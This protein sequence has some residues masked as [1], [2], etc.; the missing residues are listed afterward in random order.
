LLITKNVPLL[1]SS[2]VLQQMAALYSIFHSGQNQIQCS[3]L[4][5]FCLTGQLGYLKAVVNLKTVK[6]CKPSTYDF[7]LQLKDASEAL[8]ALICSAARNCFL[9]KKSKVGAIMHFYS[10]TLVIKRLG[11][12]VADPLSYLAADLVGMRDE[13]EKF[14]RSLDDNYAQTWW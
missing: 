6:V 5:S 13:E 8:F 14:D 11:L 10:F 1:Y 2:A 7:S 9:L 12:A 4:Q 3:Y